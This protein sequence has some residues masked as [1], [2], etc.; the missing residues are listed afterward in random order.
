MIGA[1]IGILIDRFKKGKFISNLIVIIVLIL[2]YVLGIFLTPYLWDID[3]IWFWKLYG[4]VILFSLY[5]VIIFIRWLYRKYK[6][7]KQQPVQ[8]QPQVQT[9]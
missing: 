7:K 1:F 8:T 4:P 2:I 3:L 6:S 9:K 5:G